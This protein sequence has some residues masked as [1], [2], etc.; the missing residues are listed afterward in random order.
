M[1]EVNRNIMLSWVEK[2][3]HDTSR[4]GS[5]YCFNHCTVNNH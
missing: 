4:I 2:T 1:K 3:F 5:G